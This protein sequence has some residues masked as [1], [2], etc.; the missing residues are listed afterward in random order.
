MSTT[1]LTRLKSRV[2]YTQL[3]AYFIPL[4]FQAFSASF[5]YPLVAM[6]A[7]RGPGGPLNH[8]GMAQA[9]A[10]MFF[11]GFG[12]FGLVTTGMVYGKT[13]KGFTQYFMVNATITAVIGLLQLILCIP[14]LSHWLLAVAIGLPASIEGPTYWVLLYS[15]PVNLLFILRNPYQV[16]L[17]NNQETGKASFATILRI[18]ITM[19]FAPVFVMLNLVGPFWATVCLTV[20]TILE[21]F[22]SWRFSRSYIKNLPEQNEMVTP[23]R[24]IYSF[25]AILSLGGGLIWLSQLILGAFI[26]RAPEPERI[27]PIYYVTAGVVNSLAAGATRMQ[28]VVLTFPP[29][30]KSDHRTFK[31]AVIVG[32]MLGLFVLALLIPGIAGWYFVE[33]QRLKARDLPLVYQTVLFFMLCPLTVTLRSRLEGLIAYKKKP[34]LFLTGQFIYTVAI[35]GAGWFMSLLQVSGNLIGPLGFISANLL[36]AIA[37]HGALVSFKALYTWKKR[38]LGFLIRK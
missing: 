16:V 15:I 18:V 14:P 34:G 2:T 6:I 7:S 10:I 28:A 32:L 30:N 8:A 37:L 9:H 31:F 21:V 29:K 22:L 5:N 33:I 17:Y 3:F 38:F 11:L 4:A 19:L 1:A 27:A 36:T 13:K 25:N 26:V 23:L 24:E 35:T 20:P 12:G